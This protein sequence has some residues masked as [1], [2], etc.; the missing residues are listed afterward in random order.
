R[1]REQGA[2]LRA[3][4]RDPGKRRRDDHGGARRARPGAD[5]HELVTVAVLLDRRPQPYRGQRSAGHLEVPA[6][7]RAPADDADAAPAQSLLERAQPV[8]G[9]AWALE[10]QRAADPARQPEAAAWQPPRGEAE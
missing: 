2:E 9:G 1:G 6:I 7:E 8:L 10:P 5:A 4:Q 3:G